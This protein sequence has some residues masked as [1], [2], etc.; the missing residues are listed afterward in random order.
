MLFSSAGA[1]F[2]NTAIASAKYKDADE[3]DFE[4][5]LTS[6]VWITSI[7]SIILTYI[8]SYLMIP[9]LGTERSGGSWLPSSPAEPRR[10]LIPEL[11]KV[12]TSTKSTTSRKSSNRRRKAELPW[13]PVGIRGR[14]FSAYWLG[15]SMVALMDWLLLQSG[16]TGFAE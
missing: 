6:L 4:T 2:L 12:F 1:Y 5:P 14:Q 3:M 15:L 11:V 7:V 9:N 16:H 10:A 13:D 8:V